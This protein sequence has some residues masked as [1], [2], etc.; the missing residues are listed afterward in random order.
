MYT[1]QDD[2]TFLCTNH[3]CPSKYVPYVVRIT[4]DRSYVHL[5]LYR[6]QDTVQFNCQMA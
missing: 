4:I 2:A 1:Y 3:A 5:G 6:P